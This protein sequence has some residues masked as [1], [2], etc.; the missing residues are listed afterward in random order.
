MIP[1]VGC[2]MT[3]PAPRYPALYQPQ[4]AVSTGVQAI[5]WSARPEQPTHVRLVSVRRTLPLLEPN[6]VGMLQDCLER[7]HERLRPAV[8][9]VLWL[10][11]PEQIVG[12]R[13][14][15]R[16]GRCFLTSNRRPRASDVDEPAVGRSG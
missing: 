7:S 11:G 3:V 16:Y 9:L 2:E 6:L 15:E 12:V 8:D 14:A 13:R 4:L 1:P 5:A 10:A